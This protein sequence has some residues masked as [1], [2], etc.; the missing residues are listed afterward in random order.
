MLKKLLFWV[1][2]GLISGVNA[3]EITTSYQNK[4]VVANLE[5]IRIDSIGLNPSYFK[6]IDKLGN[7]IGT[8][9]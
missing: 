8:E 4:K 7:E 3:Q 1:A 5:T 9:F 6:V 2:I